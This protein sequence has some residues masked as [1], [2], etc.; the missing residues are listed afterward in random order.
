MLKCTPS[1]IRMKSGLTSNSDQAGRSRSSTEGL[2]V[3]SETTRM[4]I[5][6]EGQS[7]E[8]CKT[9]GSVRR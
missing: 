5:Q 7:T 6:Q 2:R 9:L 8:L 1:I 3:S 4:C